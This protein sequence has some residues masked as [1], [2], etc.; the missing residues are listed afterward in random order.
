V[1]SG[2][3]GPQRNPELVGSLILRIALKVDQLDKLLRLR[4]QRLDDLEQPDLIGIIDAVRCIIY[5]GYEAV[6]L[7]VF[8]SIAMLFLFHL[9]EGQI[10]PDTVHPG[11][12]LPFGLTIG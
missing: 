7:L 4:P 10:S 2:F 11:E 8:Q 5:Q 6:N 3:R 9:I 12:E 1:Q